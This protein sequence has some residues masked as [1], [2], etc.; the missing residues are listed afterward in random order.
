MT[1]VRDDDL[2]EGRHLELAGRGTTFV[3]DTGPADGP[4]LLLLH[5]WTTSADLG[6]RSAF[7]ALAEHF[8]V[9]ALDHRG[10]GR[11]IRTEQ[12]FSLEDCADDAAAL[13][14]ALA[15]GPVVPVG[16]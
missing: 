12:R 4:T 6:W 1:T 5:G 11:G 16:Y 14:H 15:L 2:P 13:V 10:H 7:P 3:R 9:V 8:R